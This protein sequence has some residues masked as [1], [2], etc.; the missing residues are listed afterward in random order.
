MAVDPRIVVL[1]KALGIWGILWVVLVHLFVAWNWDAYSVSPRSEAALLQQQQAKAAENQTSAAEP[2]VIQEIRTI[3]VD[4]TAQWEQTLAQTRARLDTTNTNIQRL[5]AKQA[6]VQ[7]SIVRMNRSLNNLI[8][9][10]KYLQTV[11][12]ELASLAPQKADSVS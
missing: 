8:V 10:E 11:Q 1:G 6:Q 12:E 9:K 2:E 7:E 3:V 5:Q 4:E